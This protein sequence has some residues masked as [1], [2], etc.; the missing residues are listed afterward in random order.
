MVDP[1][2]LELSIYEGIPHL[3]LPVV[4]DPRKAAARCVGRA[5]RWT[6]ATSC[7]SEAGVRNITGYNTLVETEAKKKAAAKSTVEA[8][9]TVIKPKAEA[10]KPVEAPK[11]AEPVAEAKAEEA[12]SLF[13]PP[14]APKKKKRKLLIVDVGDGQETPSQENVVPVEAAASTVPV[15]D[16]G[17][18]APAEPP[19]EIREAVTASAD[20]DK[21]VEAAKTEAEIRVEEPAVD[22]APSEQEAAALAEAASTESAEPPA[23]EERQKLPYIVVIIDEL[24]DL[25]MVASKEVETSIARLAQM[26]RAAGIHLMVATQ[27][28]VDRRRHRHH[29]G[30]LPDAHQLHAAQQARLD[31]DHRNRRR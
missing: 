11:A 26:A 8:K 20:L 31:D 3:L 21:A 28:P 5:T 9:P 18:A 14:E 17:V 25:M 7:L 29:Q 10:P 13:A 1:K 2:M 19:E 6:A 4:T 22:E 15:M 30:E 27:R 24:A 23:P 16:V 12:P